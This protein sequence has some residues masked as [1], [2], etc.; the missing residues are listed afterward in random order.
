MTKLF[1]AILILFSSVAM[2][3]PP[4]G[5]LLE[6]EGSALELKYK[7]TKS[8]DACSRF[9]IAYNIFYQEQ[10]F[11]IEWALRAHQNLMA[12][13]DYRSAIIYSLQFLQLLR[14]NSEPLRFE[15]LITVYE[16]NK[17]LGDQ[18]DAT[19]NNW[20]L[21][22]GTDNPLARYLSFATFEKEFP[23]SGKLKEVKKM[24]AE[25]VE[26]FL[27]REFLIAQQLS[28]RGNDF[29]ALTR[30]EGLLQLEPILNSTYL[31][32]VLK[33]VLIAKFQFLAHW[34]KYKNTQLMIWMQLPSDTKL[35][36]AEMKAYIRDQSCKMLEAWAQDFHGDK[37]TVD[38]GRICQ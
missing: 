3:C 14:S 13:H 9:V 29:A 33:H 22:L 37:S 5:R 6:L 38:P 16:M 30:L 23:L 4:P 12:A 17:K 35:N 36:R 27:R 26:F 31:A 32:L 21:G 7:N 15:V 2:A 28:K 20:A 11:S 19:W 25:M 34:D 10:P 8:S 18:G 24:H 1:L